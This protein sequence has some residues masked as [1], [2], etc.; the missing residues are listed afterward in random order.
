LFQRI[1]VPNPKLINPEYTKSDINM[2]PKVK[3]I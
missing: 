1:N 2:Y 3:R